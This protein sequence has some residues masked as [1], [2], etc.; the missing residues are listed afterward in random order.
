MFLCLFFANATCPVEGR[1][2]K[3]ILQRLTKFRPFVFKDWKYVHGWSML[4]FVIISDHCPLNF[5]IDISILIHSTHKN[6]KQTSFPNPS[7]SASI[8]V[9]T[10]VSFPRMLF[11][12][13]PFFLNFI[14][15][16]LT[17]H[18]HASDL[19]LAFFFS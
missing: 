15:T 19:D 7:Y 9:D 2:I 6:M 16:Y 14:E 17:T 10:T 4:L 5:D 3:F 13:F 12:F 11:L 8:L 1:E 18:G